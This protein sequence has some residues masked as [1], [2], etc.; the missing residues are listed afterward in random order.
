MLLWASKFAT[1]KIECSF[2]MGK[3]T[4]LGVSFILLA[5][6]CVALCLLLL[7]MKVQMCLCGFVFVVNDAMAGPTATNQSIVYL[8]F[9][10]YK[11]YSLYL[12]A[13]HTMQHCPKPPQQHL[14][15]N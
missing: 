8:I 11:L 12:R 10:I 6:V 1:A 7:L 13:I 15:S 4:P 14:E 2:E 3:Q 9:Y 5:M